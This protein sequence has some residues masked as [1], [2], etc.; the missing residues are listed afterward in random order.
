M[1]FKDTDRHAL[2]YKTSY[3]PHHIYRGLIKYQLIRFH[4]ICTYKEDID[5]ATHILFSALKP[6]RYSTRFLRQIK[7]EVKELF[8][9]YGEYTENRNNEPIIRLVVIYSHQLT[10]L[11]SKIKTHF[12]EVQANL[13]G[14]QKYKVTTAYRRNK[15]VR[16]ILIKTAFGKTQKSEV[17]NQKCINT[18]YLENPFSQQGWSFSEDSSNLIYASQCSTCNKIYIGETGNTLRCR[19][20]QHTYHIK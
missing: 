19:M 13:A 5:T 15:N 3:H 4:R 20:Y 8:E 18:S 2:L 11:N 1:Y 14:L 12:Q 9:S 10:P 17:K 6:R 7:S 16:D